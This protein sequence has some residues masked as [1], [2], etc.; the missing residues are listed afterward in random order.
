MRKVARGM[1]GFAEVTQAIMSDQ[2]F[3][4]IAFSLTV[5]SL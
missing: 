2:V 4:D 5:S 1:L 3:A